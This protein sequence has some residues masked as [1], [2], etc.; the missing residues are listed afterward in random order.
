MPVRKLNNT[1]RTLKNAKKKIGSQT[2][3]HSDLDL[4]GSKIRNQLLSKWD[5]LPANGWYPPVPVR[6]QCVLA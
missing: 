6:P 4:P 3:V 5:H 1:E 2:S